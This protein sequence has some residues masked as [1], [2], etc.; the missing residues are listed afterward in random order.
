LR[1]RRFLLSGLLASLALAA[2]GAAAPARA[3]QILQ[4]DVEA[5]LTRTD[6]FS[7]AE[8]ITYDF[9]SVPKH[10]IYRL[11]P[12]RYGRGPAADYRI[13]VDVDGVTDEHGTRQPWKLS[14]EGRNLKI[15]IGD[16]DRTVTGVK[17]YRILYRVRRGLLYFKDHDEIYWNATGNEWPVPIAAARARVFLPQGVPAGPEVSRAAGARADFNAR[18]GTKRANAW[19]ACYTGPQGS[20]RADCTMEEEYGGITIESTRPLGVGEGLTFV[21]GLPKGVLAEPSGARRMLDRVTDT[22]SA[23]VLLPGVVLLGMFY[24]WGSQGRDPAGRDAVPVRYEPPAGLTPAEV[25]TILDERADI[26]DI[27]ATIL[28]LAV[29]GHL[30]IEELETTKFLFFSS[31]DYRLTRFPK[32]PGAL[33]RHE[34]RLVNALFKGG[35]SVLISSLREKFH[36]NIPDIK[37]AL[38]ESLAKDGGYFAASPEGVRQ[39]YL[40][41][42][43]IVAVVGLAMALKQVQGVAP[44]VCVLVTGLIVLAFGPFMPR[45]T[46][47]GRQAYQEILG[48]KEFV[49]RVDAERLER[50]GGRTAETFEKVLPF[51]IV[52]GVADQWADAFADIYKEPPRWYVG[53]S[54]ANGFQPRVFVSDMGHSL[55]TIGST[56]TSTPSGGSGGSG[57]SGGSSGGGFGGGG[58]G[59]W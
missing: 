8:D 59:S 48:L 2:S 33:K 11:I 47:K 43:I 56:L 22:V 28:D 29:R 50:M 42:G 35:D 36:T 54:Y 1:V 45:R 5:R 26:A 13:A 19:F 32:A 46:H 17:R 38:Y 25:G 20:T 16:P 49:S 14:R 7:V 6:I 23:W 37:K 51:A 44:G 18:S 4:F 52:L 21:V 9:G 30:W 15:R 34:A 55:K 12:V 31:K 58:G 53:S 10:G 24:L 3:E 39:A 40:V 27:T 41:V 57:F